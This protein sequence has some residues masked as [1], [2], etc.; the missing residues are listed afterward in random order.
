[1]VYT[2]GNNELD[3]ASAENAQEKINA[4]QYND[5][6]A[7]QVIPKLALGNALMGV[8]GGILLTGTACVIF[9]YMRG[10]SGTSTGFQMVP[11]YDQDS[12]GFAL[13]ATF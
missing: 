13:N 9:D 3:S 12:A 8:G 7:D 1:M 6:L 10:D 5:R 2:Q 4:N 11:Q